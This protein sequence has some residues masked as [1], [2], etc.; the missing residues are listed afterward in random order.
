MY[1]LLYTKNYMA[2]IPSK[3]LPYKILIQYPRLKGARKPP[4]GASL[5]WRAVRNGPIPHPTPHFTHATKQHLKMGSNNRWQNHWTFHK[6]MRRSPCPFV[7]PCI[8]SWRSDMIPNP[9]LTPKSKGCHGNLGVHCWN[10]V[11]N[12]G[13][14]K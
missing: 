8:E 6:G 4:N 11:V 2:S 13:L 1:I 12:N 10:R 7:S 14:R 3:K 5:H 9:C